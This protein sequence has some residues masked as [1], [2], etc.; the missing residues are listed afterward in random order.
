[1]QKLGDTRMT[2][3]LPGNWKVKRSIQVTTLGE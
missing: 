2:V 1:M 3:D